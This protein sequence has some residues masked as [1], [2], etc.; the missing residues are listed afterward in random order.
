MIGE[1]KALREDMQA[2]NKTNME[3]IAELKG[4]NL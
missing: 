3:C 1:L 2:A 4:I